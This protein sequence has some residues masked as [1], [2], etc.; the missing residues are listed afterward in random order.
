MVIDGWLVLLIASPHVRLTA[1]QQ[2]MS[3]KSSAMRAL[4]T[5]I[6]DSFVDIRRYA[7]DLRVQRQSE[8]QEKHNQ[9]PAADE[10][11]LNA[12]A[13]FAD[14]EYCHPVPMT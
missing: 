14:P 13:T 9:V 6:D 12:I 7:I 2:Q 5:T 4:V 10:V 8:Y 11:V 3:A 1:E